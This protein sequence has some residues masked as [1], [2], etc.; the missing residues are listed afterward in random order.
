LLYSLAGAFSRSKNP[1]RQAASGE[2]DAAFLPTTKR[3]LFPGGVLFD[4]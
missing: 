4:P 3:R 2:A 1:E